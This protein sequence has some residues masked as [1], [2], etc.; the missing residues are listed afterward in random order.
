MLILLFSFH[1]RLHTNIKEA[2]L[3]GSGECEDII[4]LDQPYKKRSP[5]YFHR[6]NNLTNPIPSSYI[7]EKKY[8]VFVF[9]CSKT[10]NL[11]PEMK[12]DVNSR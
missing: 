6:R 3:A 8:I 7:F 12:K 10:V 5:N 2:I 1:S 9:K 11:I 4:V